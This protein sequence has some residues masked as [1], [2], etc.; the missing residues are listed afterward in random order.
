MF[1][2]DVRAEENAPGGV[3]PS[4]T[5]PGFKL[6]SSDLGTVTMRLM[7]YIRYLNQDRLGATYT[8]SFGSTS[9]LDRRQDIHLNKM[10]LQ[11]MGW[12]RD[13]RL[14]YLA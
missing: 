4:G 1:A 10:N 8:D 13:P 9:A 2:C 12:A 3:Q 5:S 11:F 14:R 6:V 7:T